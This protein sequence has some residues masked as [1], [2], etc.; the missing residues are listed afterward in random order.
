MK[1]SQQFKEGTNEI[2]WVGSNFK[3]HF[4]GLDF[5]ESVTELEAKKLPR[6]MN[7]SEIIKEMNP[8]TVLLG[9]V[10]NFLKSADRSGWYIFYVNDEKGVLWAVRARWNSGLGWAVEASSVTDPDEWR[11]GGRV[12]SRRFSAPLGSSPSGTL[13]PLSLPSIHEG[14]FGSIESRIAK[15]EQAL[16]GIKEAI[17]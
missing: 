2:Y 11:A 16:Q 13:E 14:R 4:Y 8:E 3:E 10:L 6:A 17:A 1:A 12:V 5:E 9:D 7:D 15:L